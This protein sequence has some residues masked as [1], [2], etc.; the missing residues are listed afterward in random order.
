M[1]AVAIVGLLA[2]LCGPARA[3]GLNLAWNN[4]FPSPGA[5]QDLTFLCDNS[6]PDAMDANTQTFKIV[7]SVVPGTDIHGLIA[8]GATFGVQGKNPTAED[9]WK[10]GIGECREGAVTFTFNGFTN[11]TTCNKQ[12][13]EADSTLAVY[14]WS[15]DFSESVNMASAANYSIGVVRLLPGFNVVANTQYQLCIIAIDT[16]NTM[17]NG[18]GTTTACA[19]CLEPVCFVLGAVELDVLS[20]QHPPDG[21]TWVTLPDQRQFV[22]WQGGAIGGLGCPAQVP[23]RR[24]TWGELKSS[25]R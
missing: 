7:A 8:W 25:Y 22:T 1:K 17:V 20:D 11:A 13:M 4:C 18:D 3:A 21:K 5:A 12:I 14:R 19:G 9:W 23:A 16:H 6:Y 2:I 10:L 15:S 24:T